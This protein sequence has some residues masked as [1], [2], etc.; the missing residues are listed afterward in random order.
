[1]N[2]YTNGYH[3]IKKLNVIKSK[4]KGAMKSLMNKTKPMVKIHILRINIIQV[5]EI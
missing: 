4:K 5:L 3:P 1:M 2:K